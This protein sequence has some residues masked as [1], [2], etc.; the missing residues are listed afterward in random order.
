MRLLT[1][2]DDDGRAC[3]MRNDLATPAYDFTQ[4]PYLYFPA[5]QGAEV[6]QAAQNRG[7][8]QS[9]LR[10]PLCVKECPK[11]TGNIDCQHIN[12]MKT[13]PLYWNQ[14]SNCVTK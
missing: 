11:A 12:I 3:G 7:S 13:D 6:A 14:P 4:Y 1:T 9:P 8:S 2:F 5:L 10:Y